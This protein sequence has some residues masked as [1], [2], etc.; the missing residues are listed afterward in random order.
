MNNICKES[1]GLEVAGDGLHLRIHGLNLTETILS[2][3]L[4]KS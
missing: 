3:S 2:H 4:P 1:N